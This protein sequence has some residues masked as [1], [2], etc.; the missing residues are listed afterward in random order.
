[1][2]TVLVKRGR[3]KN[4]QISRRTLLKGGATWA[5]LP[6]TQL[7]VDQRSGGLLY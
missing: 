4:K 3:M 2:I 7:P 1:M 6:V 5:G